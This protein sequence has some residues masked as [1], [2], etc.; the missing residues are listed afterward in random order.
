MSTAQIATCGLERHCVVLAA[1]SFS[2]AA[3]GLRG[4]AALVTG[5]F[6]QRAACPPTQRVERELQGWQTKLSSPQDPSRGLH[7]PLNK[8]LRHGLVCQT[9]RLLERFPP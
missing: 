6:I 1:P 3:R 2:G 9:P 5:P 8:H 7:E 4:S